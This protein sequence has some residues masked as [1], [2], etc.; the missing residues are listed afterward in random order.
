[1]F[2]L[3][4]NKQRA[5]CRNEG[6]WW[7]KE[8]RQQ[9]KRKEEVCGGGDGMRKSESEGKVELS[10]KSLFVSPSVYFTTQLFT[11]RPLYQAP[12]AVPLSG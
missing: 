11:M 3:Q 9:D 10:H 5:G 7:R 8:K 1:M 4:I 12:V 2:L 6:G